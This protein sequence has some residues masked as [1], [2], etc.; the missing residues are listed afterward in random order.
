MGRVVGKIGWVD[1]A[2]GDYIVHDGPA[3]RPVTGR[4]IGKG[5]A[6]DEIGERVRLARGDGISWEFGRSRG[7]G[8][9]M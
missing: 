2:P 6:G 1:M 3:D 8:I 4:V 9:G 5:L 7:I